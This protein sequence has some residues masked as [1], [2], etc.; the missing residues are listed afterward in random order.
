MNRKVVTK[1]NSNKNKKKIIMKKIVFFIV[2]SFITSAAIAQTARDG[3]IIAFDKNNSYSG[4][5]IDIPAGYDVKTVAA[6]LQKRFETVSGL[7]GSSSG[8]FRAYL[9][10][11]FPDFGP[12]NY[13]IYTQATEIGKKKDKKMVVYLLVSKG[14][15]NFVTIASDPDVVENMKVFLNKFPAFLKEYQTSE[16]AKEQEK[17]IAKLEKENKSLLSDK[18][19]LQK[20][21]EKKDSEIQKKQDELNQA[22]NLLKTLKPTK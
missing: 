22:K 14:N 5:S 7:K 1:N 2:A 19:K 13:D 10:Q 15:N 8:S 16:K 6:A 3:V 4:V 20:Q 12:L 17:I 11:A 18:E 21:M 9:G